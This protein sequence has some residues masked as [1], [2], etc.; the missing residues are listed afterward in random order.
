MAWTMV[1]VVEMERSG[2]IQDIFRNVLKAELPVLADKTDVEGE[3]KKL[4]RIILRFVC[5]FEPLDG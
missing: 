1:I 3:E 4:I 5:L 2:R